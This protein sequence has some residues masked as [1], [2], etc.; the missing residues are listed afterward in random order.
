MEK[1]FESLIHVAPII[2]EIS[3]GKAVITI[4]NKEE[5]IYALDSKYAKSSLQVGHKVGPD[6]HAKSG[7]NDIIYKQKKTL[8]C[9]FNKATHGLDSKVTMVPAINEN[10][11]VVGFI[12]LST[13]TESFLKLKNST[14]D[15]K[16]S[17]EETNSTLSQISNS[18]LQ[19]SSKL[20]TLIES[21]KETEKYITE[22]SAAVTLIESISKQSNLLGLNA[23]IESSRAGEYGR[24]F[25]VVAGEMRKLA[26]N[27]GE[28]SKIISTALAEM[29]NGMKLIMNTINDLGQIATNQATSL[30][31][32]STVVEQIALNS[33]VLADNIN[34]D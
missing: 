23:A 5:C 7:I 26:S 13:S 17:L 3:G 30:E 4:W 27:S 22:S 28:S 9:V 10:N 18:A 24:G 1:V 21:T 33:K 25:S 14:E 34:M 19:L 12:S 32:L 31:D 6:F 16:V 20:N 29:S 2:S 11:E 15:L 8:T